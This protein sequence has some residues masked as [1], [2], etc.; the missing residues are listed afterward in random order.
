MRPRSAPATLAIVPMVVGL[1]AA[2]L[3]TATRSTAPADCA[4]LL[5][6]VLE[7]AD[8][9]PDPL[10]APV[11][12]IGPIVGVIDRL[13]LTALTE[14]A[15]FDPN[16]IDRLERVLSEIRVDLVDWETGDSLLD[17]VPPERIETLIGTGIELGE[18]CQP[19][20]A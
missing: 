2:M 10:D 16:T 18:P 20:D 4:D 7:V 14:D 11:D 12:D 6:Q 19:D 8:L 3:F 13:D 15:G 17:L 5:E 1:L 9:L